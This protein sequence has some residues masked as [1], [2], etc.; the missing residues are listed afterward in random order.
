MKKELRPVHDV[1]TC[2][3]CGRTILKGERAESYLAPGGQ[4]RQV[5]DLC[6]VRAQQE[7][8][9]RESAAGDMPTRVPRSEPRRGVLS[10]LRRRAPEPPPPPAPP[11]SRYG[12]GAE[13]FEQEEPRPAP[14]RPRP[15]PKDPRHVR[16][17]PTTAQAKVDRALE[18]F[19]GSSHQRTI[20][21][22]ARTLGTPFVSAQP[23]TAQGSQ[24]SVVVAWELSWYRYRVDLGDEAD[25]VMMLDKGEE[26]EQI[27]E[28][29]RDWN[30][31][32]DADGRVLA[33]HSVND[34]GSE[35]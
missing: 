12:N 32:L 10:R 23:D 30:A 9:I 33:G 27:D 31:R 7:G 4:R 17:I 3:V 29:L 8:W 11:P 16:A 6:S 34:G 14:P 24:V 20:A 35:A 21:G 18:L 1:V 15:S 25:P 13:Q 26:I 28:G 22:L 5:C 2:D 19:N